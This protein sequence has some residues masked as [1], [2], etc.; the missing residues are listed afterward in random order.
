MFAQTESCTH[1]SPNGEGSDAVSTSDP[2]TSLGHP[3]HRSVSEVISGLGP[4]LR[5]S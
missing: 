4:A 2:R 1:G 3:I 5:T